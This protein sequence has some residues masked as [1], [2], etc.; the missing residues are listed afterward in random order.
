MFFLQIKSFLS[1]GDRSKYWKSPVLSS[2][3][4]IDDADIS[5]GLMKVLQQSAA[6]WSALSKWTQVYF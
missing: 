6:G 4:E 1:S 3:N 5:I 2:R